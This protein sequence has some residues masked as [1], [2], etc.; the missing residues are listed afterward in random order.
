MVPF[1]SRL[2]QS[3]MAYGAPHGTPGKVLVAD[4]RLAKWLAARDV[5]LPLLAYEAETERL[6]CKLG[7][8]LPGLFE[9]AAVLCSGWAPQPL[10]DG[11]VLYEGVTSQVAEVLWATLDPKR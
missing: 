10:K 1:G 5:S 4:S 8:Q 11:T 3:C 9:R 6:V 7:S 2:G